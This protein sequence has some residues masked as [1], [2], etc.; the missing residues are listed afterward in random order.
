MATQLRDIVILLPGISGSVL[1]KNGKVV[2]GYSGRPLGTTLMTRGR[3]LREN[4]L[5]NGDHPGPAALDDGIVA[6]AAMPDL[7]L[8]PGL[9]KID[10]YTRVARTLT[11][12]FALRSQENYFEF[13][14]DW[15]R[16]NRSSAERLLRASHDWLK[17][18]REQGNPDAQLILVAHSM[19]GLVARYFLEVLGGWTDTR[20]LIT[21]GTPYRGSLNAIDSIAN[22]VR[23]GPFGLIDLSAAL[24]SFTSIYQLLPT[25][26]AYADTS[27]KLIRVSEAH[28]IPNLDAA[29]AADALRFHHEIRDAVALNRKDP[30]WEEKHYDLYPIAGIGQETSQ[31]ALR[32][33]DGVELVNSYAGTDLSGDGTVPRVSAIPLE[34]EANQVDMYAATK[35]GS[36]QNADAVLQHLGGRIEDF[37]L[38]LGGFK[39]AQFA[40]QEVTVALESE[41]LVMSD[42]QI[43]VSAKPSHPEVSLSASLVGGPGERVL[44]TIS[45]EAASGSWQVGAFEPVSEGNYRVVISG[46]GVMSPA[47]DAIAVA[48]AT[49]AMES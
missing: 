19:G 8:L 4:L 29:M 43:P 24:R 10:G 33:K 17:A 45:L 6:T 41:D 39:N 34:F 1:Q 42:E 27:G 5:L 15:R 48:D 31:S 32:L 18:W 14:Y 7:H 37:Y 30:R 28:D 40:A 46:S 23:K 12:R 26:P 47:T 49:A 35:H 2:W 38:D 25:Y 3:W 11:D 22:G 13:P 20:A 16:D 21:F 44:Q 9:W 36:L